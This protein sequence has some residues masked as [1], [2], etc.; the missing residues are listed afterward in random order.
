MITVAELKSTLSC[1]NDS[2]VVVLAIGD[3]M[4]L[5][6]KDSIH[7]E[8][9]RHIKMIILGSKDAVIKDKDSI[10]DEYHEKINPQE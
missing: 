5:M 3:K 6:E 1:L 4:A 9:E 8:P 2:M 10:A 7:V